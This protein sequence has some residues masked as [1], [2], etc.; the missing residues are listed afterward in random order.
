M[1]AFRGMQL[2]GIAFEECLAA[3]PQLQ[4]KTAGRSLAKSEGDATIGTEAF[5]L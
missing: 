3:G 5:P 4:P 1:K 2:W